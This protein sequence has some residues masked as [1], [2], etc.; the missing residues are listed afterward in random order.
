MDGKNAPQDTF[1]TAG[2]HTNPAQGGIGLI[3]SDDLRVT[4]P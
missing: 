4:K 2:G 3:Y 1:P